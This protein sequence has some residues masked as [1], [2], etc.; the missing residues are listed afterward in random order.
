MASFPAIVEIAKPKAMERATQFLAWPGWG[1]LRYAALLSF[2]N[3]LWFVLVYGGMLAVY[4]AGGPLAYLDPV[5]VLAPAW[6]PAGS[7][8]LGEAGR[9]IGYY[10][11]R[12]FLARA[13]G[14]LRGESNA[15]FDLAETMLKTGRR[16]EAIGQAEA[17][18]R[19][20]EQIRSPRLEE[21]RRALADWSAN[22]QS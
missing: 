9:A 1:H 3:T 16:V 15:L 17:A 13:V 12:L 21:A 11:Q 5:N 4:L 6:G 18:I 10:Q 2:V 8:E 7:L 20:F 22:G 19:I 14:D